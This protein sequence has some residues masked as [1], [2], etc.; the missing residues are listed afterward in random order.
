MRSSLMLEH[1]TNFVSAK[2]SANCGQTNFA[3]P[4]GADKAWKPDSPKHHMPKGQVSP[5]ARSA[6]PAPQELFVSGRFC[7]RMARGVCPPVIGKMCDVCGP[8]TGRIGPPPAKTPMFGTRSA[9]RPEAGRAREAGGR[10]RSRMSSQPGIDFADAGHT[11]CCRSR[12]SDRSA[13]LLPQPCY[14][15]VMEMPAE[16]ATVVASCA[17]RSRSQSETHRACVPTIVFR[18]QNYSDR[19]RLGSFREHLGHDIPCCQRVRPD[20]GRLQLTS[21]RFWPK[22]ELLRSKSLG[23]SATL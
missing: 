9:V 20:P 22:S 19:A 16:D 12:L 3:W 13:L 23:R 2:F 18:L 14:R 7:G 21:V 15:A 11:A 1:E 6:K 4:P 8:Q 10:P 17:A 5:N